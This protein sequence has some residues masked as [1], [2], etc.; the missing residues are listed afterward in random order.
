MAIKTLTLDEL[1][2]ILTEIRKEIGGNAPVYTSAGVG[3]VVILK[4][5]VKVADDRNQQIVIIG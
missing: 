4:A 2:D 3:P 5:Q 1:I